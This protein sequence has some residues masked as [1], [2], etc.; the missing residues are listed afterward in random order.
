MLLAVKSPEIF[1]KQKAYFLFHISKGIFHGTLVATLYKISAS[2]TNNLTKTIKNLSLWHKR[3]PN[4][5]LNET[6]M[7][8]FRS[9]N[10]VPTQQTTSEPLF[11]QRIIASLIK[12]VVE[13]TSCLF[14]GYCFFANKAML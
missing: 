14:N 13:G 5:V 9:T 12:K 7:T 3:D 8:G 6:M 10:P 11:Q 4:V 2:F 1:P